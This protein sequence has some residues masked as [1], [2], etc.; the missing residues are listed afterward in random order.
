MGKRGSGWS[1]EEVLV[2]LRVY[3]A[4]PFGR[5]HSGNPEIVRIAEAMGRSPGS[6]AMKACNL[7]GLDPAQKAGGLGNCSSLDKQVW[8]EF[9]S[10]SEK[11]A[12]EAEEVYGRLVLGEEL[13]GRDEKIGEWNGGE[14][15][16]VREVK[17][18]RAQGFFRR[19]VMVSYDGRCAVSGVG[20]A[21]LLVASHI[22]PWSEDEERRADPSNGIL[23]NSFYDRSF[24]AGF[25]T[26]DED[27][28]LV[29]ARE[30]KGR[31]KQPGFIVENVVRRE[32]ERLRLPGRFVPDAE[33]M[34]WHRENVFRG[35]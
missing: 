17:A 4:L 6:V 13:S 10:D 35:S 12:N 34:G 9:K 20:L 25:I 24:D 16:V 30:L 15:E 3:C 26:F 21:E 18:R 2:A 11:V 8:D 33:A 28:R 5:L 19:A 29:A 31:E 22:V 32:G 23:L 7:A 1:R 14:T 27:W